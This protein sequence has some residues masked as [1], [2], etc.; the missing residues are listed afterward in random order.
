MAQIQ[1]E[2]PREL[3]EAPLADKK[4][5]LYCCMGHAPLRL[6]HEAPPSVHPLA[7]SQNPSL[8]HRGETTVVAHERQVPMATI[9]WMP[10]VQQQVTWPKSHPSYRYSYGEVRPALCFYPTHPPLFQYHAFRQVTAYVRQMTSCEAIHSPKREANHA[11]CEWA[12]EEARTCTYQANEPKATPRE[13]TWKGRRYPYWL[14]P[15]NQGINEC[16]LRSECVVGQ[17]QQ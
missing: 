3:N 15:R 16:H 11:Q 14:R 5:V 2:A 1:K 10:K 13:A 17:T 4:D 12:E 6:P 7:P 8:T 9:H